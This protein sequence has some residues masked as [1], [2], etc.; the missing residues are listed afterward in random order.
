MQKQRR[1][2]LITTLIGLAIFALVLSYANTDVPGGYR[3][4][5][6]TFETAR[7][8]EVLEDHTE[9]NPDFP[10]TRVGQRLY[11]IELLS[12]EHQGY[13]AELRTHFFPSFQVDVSEGSRVSVFL[14]DMGGGQFDVLLHNQERSLILIA[15]VIVFFLALGLI[16]GKKGLMSIIGLI[17][18]LTNILFVLIPLLL[19]GYGPLPITVLVLVVTATV[20]L[21][22]L[23]GWGKKTA[24]AITGCL[25]GVVIAALLAGIVGNLTNVDGYNLGETD[26]LIAVGLDTDIR[27]S[28]LFISGA[29][30]ASLG[31]VMDISMTIASAAEELILSNPK[32]SSKQLFQASMNI[33]RDAMGTM[34]N[35]LILAFVGTGLSVLVVIFGIGRSFSQVMN[36]DFVAVEIIRSMAGSLGLVV[37]VPIVAFVASKFMVQQKLK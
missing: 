1:I 28:G 14:R 6:Y 37:T 26:A 32:I 18:T 9:I 34:A 22:L 10:D 19:K 24:V 36:M 31:A 23:N 29:L 12:G 25:S 11:R 27:I 5:R 33:G 17:F 16:G 2:K 4:M 13:Q 21:V 15:S 7:V 30:I 8:L 35:T 20:S 3:Y